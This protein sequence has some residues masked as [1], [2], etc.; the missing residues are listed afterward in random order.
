MNKSDSAFNS[1]FNVVL[2]TGANGFVGQSLCKHLFQQGQTVCAVVRSSSTQVDNNE[3]IAVG[4][5]KGHTDWTLQVDISKARHLL[6][7]TPPVSVADGL[8]E[9]CKHN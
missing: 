2:V 3:S 8:I 4:D 5:I 7:W 1:Q 6:S 9:T